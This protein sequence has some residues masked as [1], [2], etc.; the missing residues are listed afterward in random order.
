MLYVL[1]K[2][3]DFALICIRLRIRGW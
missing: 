2:F 1:L 3:V